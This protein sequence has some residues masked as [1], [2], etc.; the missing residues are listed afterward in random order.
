MNLNGGSPARRV[1]VIDD[2]PINLRLTAAVIRRAGFIADTS[3]TAEGGLEQLAVSPP[4][5]I[6]TDLQ[7]PGMDGLDLARAVKKNPDWRSIPVILL[8]AA[9]SKEEEV[10]ALQA[11]CACSIGKP[12]DAEVFPSMI[13]AFLGADPPASDTSL[14]PELPL[15]ELCKEFL[16]RGAAEC[17]ALL[18]QFTANRT[19]VPELDFAS[20]RKSA[21][22]WAGI[23][24]T[25]GLPEITRQARALEALLATFDASKRADLRQTL[26]GLLHQFTHAVPAP[27]PAT[28]PSKEAISDVG[29]ATPVKAVI[30]VGDD[31]P[32]IRA[33]IKLSLEAAGFECRTAADGIQTFTMAFQCRPDAIILDLNMPRMSGF[34]VLSSLRN[35][36]STHKLPV[37]LLTASHS[38]L[39]IVRAGTLGAA[40]YIVKPFDINDLLARLDQALASAKQ[41][42]RQGA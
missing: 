1:L 19:F 20:I 21:H 27:Q 37:I 29:C 41:R 13:R 4:D 3:D 36:W 33:V 18:P 25:I 39:D 42:P 6:V 31:D 28:A 23:G 12:I 17:R 7:L 16:A 11:G 5:L 22:S 14:L 26:V 10:K 40:S 8:T 34:Q 30:L 2:N 9:H 15:E 24:G 35:Q 38:E 32:T